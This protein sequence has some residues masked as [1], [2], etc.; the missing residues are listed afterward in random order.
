MNTVTAPC[1]F[2]LALSED[3]YMDAM[4]PTKHVR[5]QIAMNISGELCSR[6][7]GG[8]FRCCVCGKVWRLHCVHGDIA[9]LLYVRKG[10]P[11][12]PSYCPTC[13]ILLRHFSKMLL[14]TESICVAYSYLLY[15]L[16]N[17]STLLTAALMKLDCVLHPCMF[18]VCLLI[19]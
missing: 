14:H 7:A 6:F 1:I 18:N 13:D 5:W 15:T 10:Q 19:Y 2:L 16:A 8:D 3:P 12:G 11:S 4:R 17:S 9:G